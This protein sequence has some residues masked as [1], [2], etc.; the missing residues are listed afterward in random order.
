MKEIVKIAV[1]CVGTIALF[2]VIESALNI[3]P[4]I[5]KYLP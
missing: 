1:V 5:N 4:A 2:R 3:P